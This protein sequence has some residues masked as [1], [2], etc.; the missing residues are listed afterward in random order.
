MI[1]TIIAVIWHLITLHGKDVMGL[2][3]FEN[4]NFAL[5]TPKRLM[6]L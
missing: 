2:I 6:L 5:G 3:Y 1:E 4:R